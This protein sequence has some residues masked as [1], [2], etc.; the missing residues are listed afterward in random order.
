MDQSR[1]S[2]HRSD[3]VGPAARARG[4]VPE[5]C[6]G[7]LAPGL[8]DRVPQRTSPSLDRLL[9]MDRGHGGGAVFDHAGPGKARSGRS[10]GSS[11][12]DR[13]MNIAKAKMPH[14]LKA[15]KADSISI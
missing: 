9:D 15:S 8:L 3:V 6:G 13:G 11:L 1:F 12:I 4:R 14:R 7:A 5:D 2:H 10:S